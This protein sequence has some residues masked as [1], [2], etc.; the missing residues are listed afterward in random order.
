MDF[1]LDWKLFNDLILVLERQHYEIIDTP[2][3]EMFALLLI[4]ST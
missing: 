1:Y 4:F 2:W 3:T